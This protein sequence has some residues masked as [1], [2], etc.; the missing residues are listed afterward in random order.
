LLDEVKAVDEELVEVEV[1]LLLPP[2]LYTKYVP[3]A[4][5][6]FTGSLPSGHEPAKL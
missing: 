6:L 3:S 1:L 2:Q 4:E 5:T